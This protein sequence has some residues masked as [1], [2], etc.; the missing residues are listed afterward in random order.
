MSA[1][2]LALTQVFVFGWREFM[3]TGLAIAII[4]A[5]LGPKIRQQLKNERRGGEGRQS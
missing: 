5:I 3:L 4:V 1:A 2:E